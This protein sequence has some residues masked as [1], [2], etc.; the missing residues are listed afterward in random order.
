MEIGVETKEE[1]RKKGL[2][3]AVAKALIKYCLENGY[4]PIWACNNENE[5]SVNT[6]N[7]LGFEKIYEGPYY[8]II[9]KQI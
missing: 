4:N 1:Y 2:V 6:A 9:L 7:K 5:G 3:T 8:E